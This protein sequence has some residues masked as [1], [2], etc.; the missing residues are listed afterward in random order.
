MLFLV[1]FNPE[2]SSQLLQEATAT[3]ELYL[4]FLAAEK[5][6]TVVSFRQDS[7]VLTTT[8]TARSAAVRKAWFLGSLFDIE[9]SWSNDTC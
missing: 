3:L 2:F 5:K 8:S 6:D 9:H 1:N 7:S 4:C